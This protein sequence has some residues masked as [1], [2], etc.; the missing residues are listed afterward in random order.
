MRTIETGKPRLR[1]QPSSN[2]SNIRA[3]LYWRVFFVDF[4]WPHF[5][6]CHIF[7]LQFPHKYLCQS[8]PLGAPYSLFSSTSRASH[9]NTRVDSQSSKLDAI[10]FDLEPYYG[11]MFLQALCLSFRGLEPQNHISSYVNFWLQG[12]VQKVVKNH[13]STYV[14][15]N[16]KER[17]EIWI[18][19]LKRESLM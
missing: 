13:I 17:W 2:T 1:S 9:T 19:K 4:L 14:N 8:I 15:S 7:Y 16:Y 10:L 18:L 6:E 5:F 12:K 11:I 3:R